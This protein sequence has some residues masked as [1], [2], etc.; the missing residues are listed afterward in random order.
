MRTIFRDQQA[1]VLSKLEEQMP[2]SRAPAAASI[3]SPDEWVELFEKRV[4]PIRAKAFET[5][6]G[7][8]LEGF[9]IESF[10]MTDEMRFLLE[11]QGALLVKHANATTQNLIARQL[12]EATVEGEG[13]DQIAKRIKGVFRTRRHHARTIARTEVLKASQQ[14]QLTSYELA[15]VEKKQWHTSMDD[16][17]RD[18]HGGPGGTIADPIVPRDQPFVLDDGELASAPGLAPGGGELS[19]GNAINCRCFVL[20]VRG[21]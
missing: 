9:G 5:I 4:E 17:V 18:S 3:F 2:R 14:A 11:Q 1:S 6:L 13:V 8:T 7:E 21:E 20:P 19:A 12:A 16:A 10:T 15:G